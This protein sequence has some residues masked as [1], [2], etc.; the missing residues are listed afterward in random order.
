MGEFFER[1][2]EKVGVDLKT[3]GGGNCS[4]EI[5]ASQPESLTLAECVRRRLDAYFADLDGHTACD[6]YRLV[7]AEVERPLLRLVL[8][9]THGNLSRAA[10]VLGMHRATLRRKLDHYGMG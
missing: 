9:Y 10:E 3:D 5:N 8:E 1:V 6:L 4:G 7:V 2:R